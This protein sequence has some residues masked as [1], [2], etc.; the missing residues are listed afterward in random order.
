LFISIMQ[1][2]LIVVF[3]RIAAY[4]TIAALRD[5]VPP[6]AV[7]AAAT[8]A[9]L[10]GIIPAA[11]LNHLAGRDWGYMDMNAFLG[12]IV[13]MVLATAI[14]GPVGRQVTRTGGRG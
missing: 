11:V 3:W 8:V 14:L 2:V 9:G 13:A 1:G 10:V 6:M 12:F 4:L 5:R 7:R